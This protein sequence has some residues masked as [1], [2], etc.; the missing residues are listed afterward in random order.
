[1]YTAEL[2]LSNT[3]YHCSRL[4]ARSQHVWLLRLLK[5]DGLCYLQRS[6]MEA[7]RLLDLREELRAL[8]NVR[9]RSVDDFL[10]AV[11][12]ER[13]G[14]RLSA[15]LR[16]VVESLGYYNAVQF[17][18]NK[19]ALLF[20]YGAYAG[21]HARNRICV[22]EP[23]FEVEDHELNHTL[24]RQRLL[25]YRLFDLLIAE[26][27]ALKLIELK[28]VLSSEKN[29]QRNVPGGTLLAHIA[30]FAEKLVSTLQLLD[31]PLRE[32]GYRVEYHFVLVP[33]PGRQVD[34]GGIWRHV[35][36]LG[37]LLEALSG[38]TIAMHNTYYLDIASIAGATDPR[39][40][41][42]WRQTLPL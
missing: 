18:A 25:P 29:Q 36:R 9:L 2:L 10:G 8:G 17:L 20:L 33:G 32:A 38:A 40:K 7:Y 31:K 12:A 1:M 41:W 4:L 26:D 24:E 30:S 5:D 16:V 3:H 22:L 19:H 27:H 23:R 39:P 11:R 15:V 37:E 34:S 21:C 6:A 42:T 13:L 28:Y 14:P 35:E